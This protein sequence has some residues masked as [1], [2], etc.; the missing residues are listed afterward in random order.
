MK[1]RIVGWSGVNHSYSIIAET[2]M[3]KFANNP[4]YELYFSPAKYFNKKWVK[5]RNTFLDDLCNTDNN[6]EC[7]VT[8][9]FVYPYDLT[10]D[11]HS[12]NTIIFMTCEFNC[13]SGNID[14]D[15]MCDNVWVMTP[16]EYSKNGII[17]SGVNPRKI[18]VVPHCYECPQCTMT[19]SEIRNKYN[20]PNS[21]YVYFHNSALTPN[22][23]VPMLIEC[24]ETVY[25]GNNDVSLVIK[26][27]DN[28]YGSKDKLIEILQTLGQRT[29]VTC[30]KKIVYI[31]GDM[32]DESVGELYEMSDCYVSPFMAEGFNLPVLEALCHGLNV[33]CTKGGPPDEYARDAF[34][35]NSEWKY[36][37]E[38][39]NS[40]GNEINK[41]YLGISKNDLLRYM[42]CV[43]IIKNVVD[44]QYYMDKYSCDKV[45]HLV[46]EKLTFVDMENHKLPK[47]VVIDTPFVNDL[48][49]NIRDFCGD[50]DINVCH[51]DII[52]HI[53]T[54]DTTNLIKIRTPNTTEPSILF[55]EIFNIIGSDFVFI[56]DECLLFAD[57]RNANVCKGNTNKYYY[58]ANKLIFAYFRDKNRPIDRIDICTPSA[59]NCKKMLSQW[60]TIGDK[61]LPYI[62]NDTL[63]MNT[64]LYLTHND[65]GHDG[66]KLYVTPKKELTPLVEA[67]TKTDVAIITTGVFQ[68]YQNEIRNA[69][70]TIMFDEH[71]GTP[72]KSDIDKIGGNNIFVYPESLNYFFKS[73]YPNV[74]KEFTL[75]TIKTSYIET[76]DYAKLDVKKII[77][78]FK[79]C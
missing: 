56:S 57:P 78:N 71:D 11:V 72:T 13:V 74:N 49:H 25:R 5:Q 58:C 4:N 10:P 14:P 8:F 28:T 73:I 61:T 34:F 43:P 52:E 16:S 55:G 33:I 26:G 62:R 19:K 29:N 51:R 42:L 2:Y 69:P 63:G 20:I 67:L 60:I 6:T 21:D 76:Y 54:D 53:Q 12:R 47:I 50:V 17:N 30:H 32:T 3:K 36:S 27:L 18:F 45:F 15:A 48:I 59:S 41:K 1:I 70:L 64:K 7:D 35:I 31:G 77:S 46:C 39:L 9:R 44:R 38:F 37:D 65:I 68:K 40:R 22:K 79:M 24:F 23:N 66:M 75:S